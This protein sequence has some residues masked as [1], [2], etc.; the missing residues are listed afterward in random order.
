MSTLAEQIRLRMKNV[1]SKD[2][3]LLADKR[4]SHGDIMRFVTILRN[5]GVSKVNVAERPD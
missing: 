1:D 3:L 4:V 2:F 5:A